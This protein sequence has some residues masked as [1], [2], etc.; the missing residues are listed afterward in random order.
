MKP[1]MT[2]PWYVTSYARSYWRSILLFIA[3]VILG[4]IDAV[5]YAVGPLF[6]LV[7][8]LVG[9]MI[10]ATFIQHI[11][12]RST[13]DNYAEQSLVGDWNNLEPTEKVVLSI[14]VICVLFLGAAYIAGNIAK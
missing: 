8:M 10:G 1:K 12:F 6:Y 14:V 7:Q 13:V 11:L 4:R 3:L 9:C 2:K 5:V